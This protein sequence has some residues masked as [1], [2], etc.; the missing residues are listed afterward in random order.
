MRLNPLTVLIESYRQILLLGQQPEW[1]WLGVVAAVSTTVAYV[2]FIWFMH[3][4]RAF[5]D[6]I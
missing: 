3:S 2:G 4:K 6:V 1:I 5:G